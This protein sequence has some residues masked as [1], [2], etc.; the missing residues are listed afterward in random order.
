LFTGVA[1]ISIAHATNA[2]TLSPGRRRRR[3]MKI[4]TVALF[5]KV[6]MVAVVAAAGLMTHFSATCV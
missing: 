2:A 1:K 4:R 3:V 5:M 6:V